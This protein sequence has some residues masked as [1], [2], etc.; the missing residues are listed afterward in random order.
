MYGQ[1][2]LAMSVLHLHCCIACLACVRGPHALRRPHLTIICALSW[3]GAF[4]QSYPIMCRSMGNPMQAAKVHCPA[5][6]RRWTRKRH[7]LAAD[8]VL[9]PINHCNL[10][11][12]LATIAPS[13]GTLSYFDSMGG[14]G[15]SGPAGH[16]VL[17]TLE[18]WLVVEAKDK[19]TAVVSC[20]RELVACHLSF[21]VHLTLHTEPMLL[22]PKH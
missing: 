22:C 21:P 17:A 7:V 9:I 1:L 16:R 2:Q 12:C 15:S 11:W 14:K 13:A 3:R 5:A 18:E 6:V 4:T 10:H 8:L 19:Q 20:H